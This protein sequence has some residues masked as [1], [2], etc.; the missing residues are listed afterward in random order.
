MKAVG[1]GRQ[2][3]IGIVGPAA[4]AIGFALWRVMA[5]DPLTDGWEDRSVDLR[6]VLRG[7]RPAPPELVLVAIDEAAVDRFGWSPP[8]RDLFGNAIRM[9]LSAEPA[10][11]AVDMLLLDA[12]DHD[13]ALQAA[14]ADGSGEVIL[15]VAADYGSDGPG[16]RSAA[17]EAALVQSAVPIVVGDSAVT[18]AAPRLFAPNDRFLGRARLGHVN[19]L[20]SADR[21]ARRV[22]LTEWVGGDIYLPSLALAAAT[23]FHGAQTLT[24]RPGKNV[25]AGGQLVPT[26]HHGAVLVN[27]YGKHGAVTTYSVGDVIDGR[28]PAEALAGHVVFLGIVAESL[29]DEFATAF[30]AHTPG[31]EILATLAGNLMAGDLLIKGGSTEGATVVLAG[32]LV[33]A[34]LGTVRAGRLPYFALAVCAI[35]LAGLGALVLAFNWGNLVLD[36]PAIVVSLVVGTVSGIGQ[37]LKHETRRSGLLATERQNLSRYVSPLLAEDLARSPTPDFAGRTQAATV[38]FVDL[39]GYTTLSETLSPSDTQ[40]LLHRLH[41]VYEGAASAH[42]GVVAGFW[43]DGAMIAFGLPMPEKDDAVRALACGRALLAGGERLTV[44]DRADL[45]MQLR[46]SAHSGMVVAAMAGGEHQAQVTLNGDTVNVAS[47]LQEVAKA[48][49]VTFAISRATLTEAERADPGSTKGFSR[50][51]TAS[52][53]GR[54][55]PIEVWVA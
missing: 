24:L 25:G 44:P 19:I 26:D 13:A 36:A 45:P 21:V 50:L 23:R 46:V 11:L 22:P 37:R 6:F 20:A 17:L 27:F 5:G 54:V 39:A 7:P 34:L 4:L 49:G 35:W 48:N 30:D 16:D 52:I 41:L 18:I 2:R 33:L 9:I 42:R 28:V 40:R 43:G 32:L 8:P 10:A 51:G 12:T 15:G 55:E 53:R 38:L 1:R 31:V 47:R 3:W 29:S 14:L